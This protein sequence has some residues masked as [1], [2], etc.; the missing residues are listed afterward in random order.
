[1]SFVPKLQAACLKLPF[2]QMVKDAMVHPAGLFTSKYTTNIDCI[3]L[4][5]FFFSFLL[6]TNFQV[7][8][9]ILEHCRL[10]EA[11]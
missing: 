6:G 9:H 7:D 11:C 8:D 2:P 4:N 10:E 5:L 1:M 3:C